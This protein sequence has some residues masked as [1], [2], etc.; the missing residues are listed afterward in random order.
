RMK[1]LFELFIDL[2]MFLFSVIVL[3]GSFELI[4]LNWDQEA[5]TFPLSV[6][7]LYLAIAVSSGFIMI[8]L[9]FLIGKKVGTLFTKAK[10]KD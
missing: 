7:F 4:K 10:N 3:L 9:M 1:V 2:I 6:G 8:F 5:V